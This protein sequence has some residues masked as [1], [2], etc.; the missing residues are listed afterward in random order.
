MD[1]NDPLTGGEDSSDSSD[2]DSGGSG[3]SSDSSV[4]GDSKE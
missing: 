3:G 1:N 4:D 2:I